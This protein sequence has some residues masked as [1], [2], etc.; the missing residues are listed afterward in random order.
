MTTVSSPHLFKC[1]PSFYFGK[2]HICCQWCILLLFISCALH[3][4]PV[5]VCCHPVTLFHLVVWT[6]IFFC[7]NIFIF[8]LLLCFLTEFGYSIFAATTVELTWYCINPFQGNKTG[9]TCHNW[10]LKHVLWAGHIIQPLTGGRCNM[11]AIKS[12]CVHI[13]TRAQSSAITQ[14]CNNIMTVIHSSCQWF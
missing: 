12:C 3:I 11:Q 4:F 8:G 7:F 5:D 13:N 14:H 9:L 1:A 2:D 6:I 10:H